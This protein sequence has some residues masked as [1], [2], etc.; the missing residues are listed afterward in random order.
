MRKAAIL[1]I[2][3]FLFNYNSIA[4]DSRNLGSYTAKNTDFATS[5]KRS[6]AAL[7]AYRNHPYTIYYDNLIVEYE[8]RMKANVRK[9]K[10]MA[11]KFK[12]PHYTAP[13]FFGHTRKPKK[14]PVGKRK[15]CRECEIVH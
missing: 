11:R 13:Y 1:F 6:D 8:K 12:K 9:Y 10:V 15:Y 4:Q 5:I 14:R 7:E 3:V 2:S